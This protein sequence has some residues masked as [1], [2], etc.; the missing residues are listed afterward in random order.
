VKENTIASKL[1]NLFRP[2]KVVVVDAIGVVSPRLSLRLR[3]W[4]YRRIG[5]EE[6]LVLLPVLCDKDR[7]AIDVG[8]NYGIY[9]Y[10]MQRF[11]SKLVVLEPNPALARFLGRALGSSV[12]IVPA[13][14]SDHCGTA[15]LRV[16]AVGW[17]R[18]LWGSAT[19]EEVN[20]L[21]DFSAFET[22]DVELVTLDALQLRGVGFIK[23]DVEGHELAVLKGA[24]ELLS[25]DHPTILVEAEDRHHPGAVR[26]IDEFLSQYGYQGFFLHLDRL[27]PLGDFVV[28]KHQCR[29]N[30]GAHSG[31]KKYINNFI[32]T[33]NPEQRERLCRQLSKSDY[34]GTAPQKQS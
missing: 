30:W 19:I 5:T 22:F 25:Q 8:G 27:R 34:T 26:L 3:A 6:E 33:C 20:L 13:A 15:Q 28:E 11:C 17:R 7:L 21:Q 4:I 12:A 29:E 24:V 2:A 32:F 23:I 10:H 1:K 18:D 31:E 16:P 14:A 9:A